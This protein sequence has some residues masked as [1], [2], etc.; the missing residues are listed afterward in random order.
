MAIRIHSENGLKLRREKYDALVRQM[1]SEIEDLQS[2]IHDSDWL[3]LSKAF[4]HEEEDL[5]LVKNLTK[6]DHFCPY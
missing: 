2:T 3:T 5:L 1:K 6:V 4:A